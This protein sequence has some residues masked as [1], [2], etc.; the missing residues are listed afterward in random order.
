MCLVLGEKW[1]QRRKLI[2]SA[3]H[4]NLLQAFIGVF[5]KQSGKLVEQF[6]NLTQAES[7][8]IDVVPPLNHFAISSIKGECFLNFVVKYIKF[9]PNHLFLKI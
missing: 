5:C 6:E 8:I 1:Q 3:F 7:A 4:V 2:N 9:W